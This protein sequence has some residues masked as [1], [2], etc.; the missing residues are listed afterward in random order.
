M[1]VD[2]SSNLWWRDVLTHGK[3][4]AFA[5]FFDIDWMPTKPELAGKVL[6]P[7]LACQYG[8]ALENGELTFTF[9]DDRPVVRYG[10][11][12]LPIDPATLP[13]FGDDRDGMKVTSQMCS[14]TC[15]TPTFCPARA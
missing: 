11:I 2:P 6:L 14:L 5:R 9:A 4:S 12:E 15:V 3:R 8:Q 10:S 1:S 13:A 7:I